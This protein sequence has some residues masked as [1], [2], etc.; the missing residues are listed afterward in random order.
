MPL[1]AA[2]QAFQSG[3]LFVAEILAVRNLILVQRSEI[4]RNTHLRV[5]NVSA[6]RKKSSV[7]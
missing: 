5:R 2:P 1:R 3:I 4:F 7:F 6:Q